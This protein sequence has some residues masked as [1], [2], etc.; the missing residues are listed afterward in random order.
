MPDDARLQI[1]LRLKDEASKRMK[2]ISNSFKRNM[3]NVGTAAAGGAAVAGGAL[4]AAGSSMQDFGDEV[5]RGENAIRMGT[6][7]MGDDLEGLMDSAREVSGN[8]PQ[9]FG[10]VATA[11]ADVNTEFG[12]LGEDLEKTTQMFLD[13]G[14]VAGLDTGPMIKGV[15]DIMT[16][17]GEDMGTSNAVMGDFIAISQATG[18]P[19]D[20]LIKQ[21]Q[22]YGPILKTAGM[23]TDE[24]ASF[25]GTLASQG[26]DARRVIP[27]LQER[28][29]ELAEGGA[30][31]LAK[32]IEND[33]LALQNMGEGTDQTKLAIDLF[34]T[35]GDRMVAA[36][37]AGLIPAHEALTEKTRETTDETDNLTKDSMTTSETFD[38]MK[39]KIG[40][41]IQPFAEYIALIG[42]I[43]VPL[44]G[45]AL[46]LGGVA[47]AATML[48]IPLLPLVAVI[49][50]IVA[51]VTL[52]VVIFKN[53]D[54]IIGFFRDTWDKVWDK[55]DEPVLAIW[56]VIKSFLNFYINGFN[57]VIRGINKLKIPKW[58][59]KIGG[60]SVNIP[61]IP[62]LAEGGIVTGPTIA[63]IGEAGPE[64][65][66]PLK[67]GNLGGSTV[68]INFPQGST[69]FLD[70]EQSARALADQ[71]TQ[72]I[73]G[74]LRAQGSF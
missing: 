64:A 52:A 4:V 15:N 40:A 57:A 14:R 69:V 45:L 58:V 70:N 61:E 12:F 43:L 62:A 65:V 11:V 19:L 72:Q 67:D 35:S 53:W 56:E 47:I 18:M 13:V 31:D 51:A 20:K 39:N 54:K 29:K 48:N 73:R 71:I 41:L 25:I 36:I 22:T 32:A 55:I 26:N 33:L 21:M 27:G 68:I 50:A 8:V 38:T 16:T 30:P 1:T 46:A 74:V 66:V 7:A 17:F 23:E 37:N 42:A 60:K 6:G 28:M 34:G 3:N 10:T 24:A 9:D 59:P 49:L 5:K 44:G 2:N 63:Q